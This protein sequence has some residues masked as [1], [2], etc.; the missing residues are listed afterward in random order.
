MLLLARRS[1]RWRA[2][3]SPVPRGTRGP[4]QAEHGGGANSAIPGSVGAQARTHLPAGS[5]WVVRFGAHSPGWTPAPRLIR[6]SP[7]LRHPSC[8]SPYRSPPHR[9]GSRHRRGERDTGGGGD[10]A[11]G[12]DHYADRRL[13]RRQPAAGGGGERDLRGGDVG[14]GAGRAAADQDRRCGDDGAGVR[15]GRVSGLQRRPSEH[16]RRRGGGRS[17]RVFADHEVAAG[18]WGVS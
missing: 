3:S 16:E 8:V 17:R 18:G 6:G 9:P 7:L 10:A 1:S 4:R 13:H 5:G 15:V 12:Q 14:A 2:Q 11:N